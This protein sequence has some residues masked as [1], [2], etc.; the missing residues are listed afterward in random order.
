MRVFGAEDGA[1]AR[2]SGVRHMRAEQFH[3]LGMHAVG[4]PIAVLH[5]A[6]CVDPLVHDRR[7]HARTRQQSRAQQNAFHFQILA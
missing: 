6:L 2:R 3:D 7:C 5:L 4:R 1:G